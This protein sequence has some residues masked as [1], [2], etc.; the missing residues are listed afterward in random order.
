MGNRAA[1]LNVSLIERWEEDGADAVV[2][3]IAEDIHFEDRRVGLQAVTDGREA[4]L[5]NLGGTDDLWGESRFATPELIASR[6]EHL[7][8]SRQFIVGDAEVE[9][10]TVTEF[11]AADRMCRLLIFDPD[12]L[13]VALAEMD[14][15]HAELSNGGPAPVD[16]RAERLN[17]VLIDRWMEE[18]VDAVVDLIAEDIHFEDR[19]S[20]LGTVIDGR[21][22]HLANMRA[23]DELRGAARFQHLEVVA[24]R[25]EHLV[26]ARQAVLGEAEIELLGLAEFDADDRMRLAVMFDPDDLGSP[27]PSSSAGSRS[28][29]PASRP[30]PSWSGSSG[31]TSR[32]SPRG[33]SRPPT[34]WWRGTTSPRTAGEGCGR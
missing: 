23:V 19:R 33:R 3:L 29:P 7:V 22:A 13:E 20:G 4:H 9:M 11:D 26:L 28:S 21:E 10:L 15:R 24:V 34:S 14:R 6:G 30:N 5:A 16:N 31:G 1:R 18:G 8:L 25:G 27:W 12:D 2:D 17:L 32:S